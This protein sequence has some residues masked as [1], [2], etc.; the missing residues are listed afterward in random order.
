M[1][2]L[3]RE[4]AKLIAASS[5][6]ITHLVASS[7]FEFWQRKDFRLYVAF[8][9]VPRVE[10]DRMFNELQVSLLGLFILKFEHASDNV[11]E[12]K[13]IVFRSF[14]KDLAPAYLQMCAEMGIGEEY[15]PTWSKLIDMRLTEYRRDFRYAEKDS[16][17]MKEF[18]KESESMRITWARIE[19]L[20]IDC[21]THIRRGNVEKNDP[22]WK[23]LR[24]WFISLDVQLN[25]IIEAPI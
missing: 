6:H 10:Q 23:L 1:I 8:D 24:K 18:K 9:N 2:N 16:K 20:T 5:G 14:A 3:K 15:L 11:L 12:E 25:S 13:T 7:S 4:T 17:T 19:T 22:L 21:L